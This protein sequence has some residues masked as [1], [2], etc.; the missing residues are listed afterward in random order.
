MSISSWS[1]PTFRCASVS[2]RPASGTGRDFSP[3]RPAAATSSRHPAILAR[4]RTLHPGLPQIGHRDLLVLITCPDRTGGVRHNTNT[5]QDRLP[6]KGPVALDL[7]AKGGR[8]RGAPRRPAP[9]GKAP[10]P[11]SA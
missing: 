1:S 9:N 11:G 7:F 8:M 10:A 3:S 4:P 6:Q 5:N 2:H